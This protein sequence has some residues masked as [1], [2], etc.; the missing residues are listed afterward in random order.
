MGIGLMAVISEM[1]WNQGDDLYGW[2]NNRFLR[3]AE[4]VA[5]YNNGDD[6]VP[7]MTYERGAGTNGAVQTETV[8]SSASRNE[9]RPVWEMIYNHYA[10][11]KGL[12]VPNIA[13]RAQLLRPE[14]GPNANT[15][16]GSA[17]D[18]IGYGTLLYTRPAGSGGTATLPAGNIPDGIYRFIVSHT[19]KAMDAAGS[20]NGSSIRQ[21]TA[22]GGTNQ[23]WNVTHLG[24]GQYSI[25]NVQSGRSLDVASVSLEHGAKFQIWNN[26]GGDNQKFAFIP[27][28]NGN[29]RITP[30]A[31]PCIG[32]A[33]F[34]KRGL[35]ICLMM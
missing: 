20:S 4:Y 29:H 1:A 32:I 2:A 12:S 19:G 18:Q 14:G 22:T 3:A 30:V 7:F 13:A 6:N 10:N 5:K 23:Q 26:N 21:W 27:T 28:G 31:I 16:H 17:F 8:I 9:L 34:F 33:C 15:N 11:R 35:L 24:G 25:V